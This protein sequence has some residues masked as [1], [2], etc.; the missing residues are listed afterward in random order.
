M[1]W[2]NRSVYDVQGMQPGDII[3]INETCE[4][5]PHLSTASSDFIHT[6]DM[7]L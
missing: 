5:C 7:H 1:S 6:N 3:I 4:L 2:Y